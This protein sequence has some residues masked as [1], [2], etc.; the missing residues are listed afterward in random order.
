MPCDL[1]TF[2]S[3]MSRRGSIA[4]PHNAGA[5][6][7]KK[8]VRRAFRGAARCCALGKC[9]HQVAS[10]RTIKDVRTVLRSALH[11]AVRQELIDRNVAQLVEIPSP[12]RTGARWPPTSRPTRNGCWPSSPAGSARRR[13]ANEGSDPVLRWMRFRCPA[14]TQQAREEFPDTRE[15]R[16]NRWRR[17]HP[18][19]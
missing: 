6:H 19:P 2:A 11:S 5:A 17:Q 4:W 9:C 10:P 16:G 3:L 8:D 1:I 18:E 14:A 12:R 15:Y 13:L 7:R